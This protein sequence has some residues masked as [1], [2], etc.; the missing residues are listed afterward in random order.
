MLNIEKAV[1]QKS[2]KLYKISV[3][4][5]AVCISKVCIVYCFFDV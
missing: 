1:L 2:Q 5:S 3:D 4:A